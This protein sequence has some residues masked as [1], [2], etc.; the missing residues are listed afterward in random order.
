MDFLSDLRA[1]N[2]RSGMTEII[3]QPIYH[4]QDSPVGGFSRM[5]FFQIPIGLCGTTLADTNMKLP[6][7]MV[8]SN[9]FLIR[10]LQVSI[11][12]EGKRSSDRAFRLFKQGRVE[13]TIGSKVY[14]DYC[15]IGFFPHCPSDL[16]ALKKTKAFRSI[17][18]V[19]PLPFVFNPRLI[20]EPNQIFCV[21]LFWKTPVKVRCI[22]RIGV[23]LDGELYRV[24][25]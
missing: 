16:A 12:V 11:S 25:Q 15:P 18:P 24:S 21:T 13:L 8:P 5:G 1:T 14:L 3:S 19:C 7:Q 2:T 17:E 4:W 10:S 22:K 9:Y 20:L 23:V 6:G